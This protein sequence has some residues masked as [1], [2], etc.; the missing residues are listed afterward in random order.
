MSRELYLKVRNHVSLTLKNLLRHVCVPYEMPSKTDF[1]DVDFLVAGPLTRGPD[2]AHSGTCS[3]DYPHHVTEI[4]AALNTPHGRKGFLTE[5]IMHFAIPAPGREDEFWVQIDV[6][7][8]EREELFEWERFCLNYATASQIIGS[9]IKPVGLTLDPEGL[10]VRVEGLEKADW[11]KSLVFLTR[12]PKE[13]LEI[14]GLDRRIM[15]SGFRENDERKHISCALVSL[16]VTSNWSQ[17][18]RCCRVHG[19]STQRISSNA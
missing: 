14:M 7:V 2:T 11:E 13:L 5:R 9:M 16:E 19:S 6:K 4:K 12:E 17:S 18:S 10:H 1:G 8:C 15:C 3:F